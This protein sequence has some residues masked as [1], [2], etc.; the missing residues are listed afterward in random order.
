MIEGSVERVHHKEDSW[1][2]SKGWHSPQEESYLRRTGP[3]KQAIAGLGMKL[4][5]L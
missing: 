5:P 3:C 4:H 1:I 2:H